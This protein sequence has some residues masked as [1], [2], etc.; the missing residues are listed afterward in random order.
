[1][2]RWNK[3]SKKNSKKASRKS[4]SKKNV[5]GGDVSSFFKMP[6]KVPNVREMYTNYTN[7]EKEKK[8]QDAIANINK[9]ILESGNSSITAN[10]FALFFDGNNI[11]NDFTQNHYNSIKWKYDDSPIFVNEKYKNNIP[12]DQADIF[13]K[14]SLDGLK[15]LQT[16]SAAFYNEEN[17]KMI[18]DAI[19][20]KQYDLKINE[21]N[22]V[23]EQ[24]INEENA[25]REKNKKENQE[26]CNKYSDLRNVPPNSD[27][28]TLKPLLMN[29]IMSDCDITILKPFLEKFKLKMLEL[30]EFKDEAENNTIHIAAL[31]SPKLLLPILTYASNNNINITSAL[32][33]ANKNGEYPLDLLCRNKDNSNFASII[34]AIGLVL[35]SEKINYNPNNLF[36][37]YEALKSKPKSKVY[38]NIYDE[39]KRKIDE[40]GI[41]KQVKDAYNTNAGNNYKQIIVDIPNAQGIIEYV[42][43]IQDCGNQNQLSV[44]T[45]ILQIETIDDIAYGMALFIINNAGQKAKIA[46]T[47]NANYK[48]MVPLCLNS[49][50]VKDNNG[51]KQIRNGTVTANAATGGLQ[52]SFDKNELKYFKET[53]DLAKKMI[54][55]TINPSQVVTTEAEAEVPVVD[56]PVSEAP[57]V[58][59]P[60]SEA[61]LVN[62]PVTEAPVVNT[63]VSEAPPQAPVVTTPLVEEVSNNTDTASIIT[64]PQP[65][66][67]AGKRSRKNRRKSKGKSSKK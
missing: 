28:N 35:G 52:Y 40:A 42:K 20:K 54:D 6:I 56:T 12:N 32:N 14:F 65:A 44:D 57:L 63:P 61:P 50:L 7:K 62:T 60:V 59:T 47:N 55:E 30:L 33:A 34:D 16:L 41:S 27:I 48:R 21:E 45:N 3:T 9:K 66:Q 26:K 43:T 24:K 31:N 51:G 22:A 8:I 2:S 1:M 10:D 23:R 29:I 25:V 38:Q 67:A 36:N 53:Y 58:N 13:N 17:D 5:R 49:I 4:F 39:I 11:K 46:N 18:N 64:E 37:N 15:K 19:T